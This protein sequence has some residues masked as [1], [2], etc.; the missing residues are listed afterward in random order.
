M[1]PVTSMRIFWRACLQ[2]GEN[3][4]SRL[5]A[6]LAYYTLFSIAPLL[7]VAIYLTGFF[8]G[9]DAARGQVS[10]QLTREIGKEAA[11]AVERLV[12][13]AAQPREGPWAA[14]ISVVILIAGA[15]GLFLHL[16]GALCTIWKL[17]SPHANT[18]LSL[19]VDHVL[20]LVMVL[21][22]GGLL[23]LTLLI[24]TLLPLLETALE[25]PDS[26]LRIHLT[27]FGLSLFLLTLL[28]ASVFR[29]LSGGRIDWRYVWYGSL[30]TAFLFTLGKVLLGLYLFYTGTASAYGAA[31]SVVIFMIWI[32]YSSQIL[33]F[34]A[35]LVQARRT[36]GEWM[37]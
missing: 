29:I 2:F 34:G 33:F 11:E 4:D 32:Y 27:E 9:E 6:A 17:E 20:A 12:E 35:E 16:R 24:S 14:R 19:L 21:A 5:G 22:I 1:F 28:F 26:Q 10:R 36:R 13:Y 3:K 18:W 15:L 23:M 37:T 7:V 8:Y 25:M 30:V 31:G